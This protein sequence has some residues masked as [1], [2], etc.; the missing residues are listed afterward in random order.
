[1][2]RPLLSS[3]AMD[4]R[5]VLLEAMWTIIPKPAISAKKRD[6][7]SDGAR[8]NAGIRLLKP[9]SPRR[10]AELVMRYTS[11]LIAVCCIHEKIRYYGLK[12]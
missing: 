6:I 9:T 1:M 4:W 10:N 3:S 12:K 2:T 8:K 11:Q 5:R 7:Q